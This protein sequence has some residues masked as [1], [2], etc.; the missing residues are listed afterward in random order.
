MCVS[1]SHLNRGVSSQ[2]FDSY[3]IYAYSN[4]PTYESMP[5]VVPAEAFNTCFLQI[6][7]KRRSQFIVSTFAFF[8]DPVKNPH[9]NIQR[10]G[11]SLLK[12][13]NNLCIHINILNL[14][15]FFFPNRDLFGPLSMSFC[16]IRI[17]K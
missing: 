3:N 7:F 15:S 4:Q 1:H 14:T 11:L 16:R 13:F 12:S 9:A 5:K 17:G 10:L 8:T 2:F 6:L